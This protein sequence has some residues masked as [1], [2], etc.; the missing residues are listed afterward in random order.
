MGV[1]NAVIQYEE[2][3]SDRGT[4]KFKRQYFKWFE[5]PDVIGGKILGLKTYRLKIVTDVKN[6]T[7]T[8]K[9]IDVL[10]EA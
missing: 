1:T 2:S 5:D 3:Y 8:Y 7:P 4:L 6:G 9:T 10:G